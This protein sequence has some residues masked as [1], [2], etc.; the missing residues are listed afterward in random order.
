MAKKSKNQKLNFHNELSKFCNTTEGIIFAIPRF[1]NANS[2]AMLKNMQKRKKFEKEKKLIKKKG[3]VYVKSKNIDEYDEII[4][5]LIQVDQVGN[6][7]LPSQYVSLFI[8]FENYVRQM[9][10]LTLSFKK[11][12]IKE[13]QKSISLNEVLDFNKIEDV[14]FFAIEQEIDFALKNKNS[15]PEW[16]NTNLKKKIPDIGNL[17]SKF[18][19]YNGLRNLLVHNN[20]IVNKQYHKCCLDAGI[21]YEDLPKIGEKVKVTPQIFIK[22]G[23]Y[24][25]I[26]GINIGVNLWKHT[27]PKESEEIESFLIDQQVKYLNK[28]GF[29]ILD[30][31]SD[32]TLAS[33][34]K[35]SRK[36][37][38]YTVLINKAI[39]LK[40]E[41]KDS[42]AEEIFKKMPLN[43]KVFQLAIALIKKDFLTASEL[44]KKIKKTKLEYF[45]ETWPL[46]KMNRRSK[47]VSK[48][49]VKIIGN[50]TKL[51]Q[52]IKTIKP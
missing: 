27:K 13:T 15:L 26:M 18:A 37:N 5:S 31:I 10:R 42:E 46:F 12:R 30:L 45:Y 14:V 1:L 32:I 11:E 34:D 28:K 3:K 38:E 16:I 51:S 2:R 29:W 24:L 20:G 44:M 7:I 52:D 6:L 23:I 39:A 9:I 21:K 49:Y 48:T 35:F 4:D 40:Q 50:F 36:S 33:F 41:K 8:V 22:A 19:R 43:D 47:L 17:N 25:Y